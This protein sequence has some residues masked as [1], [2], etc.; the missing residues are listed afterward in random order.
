MIFLHKHFKVLALVLRKC[1]YYYNVYK[2]IT[3][4][5]CLNGKIVNGRKDV[6]YEVPPPTSSILRSQVTFEKFMDKMH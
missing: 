2:M 1:V 5:C 6:S 4:I 3:L